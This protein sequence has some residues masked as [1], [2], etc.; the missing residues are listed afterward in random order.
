[1]K[2]YICQICDE[3]FPASRRR[4]YCSEACKQEAVGVKRK[5]WAERLHDGMRQLS[6]D[7][8]E[9]AGD[10]SVTFQK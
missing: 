4:K 1:M 9:Q 5:S 10:E 7:F 2:E 8:G 6:D 3:P